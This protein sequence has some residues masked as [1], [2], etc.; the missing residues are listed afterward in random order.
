MLVYESIS[1]E[2]INPILLS[3]TK[4]YITSAVIVISPLVDDLL[5]S[6]KSLLIFGDHMLFAMHMLAQG[7]IVTSHP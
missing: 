2:T 5:F 3:H 7:Y 1:G 4:R 6:V